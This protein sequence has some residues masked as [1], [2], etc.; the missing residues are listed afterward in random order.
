MTKVLREDL[1]TVYCCRRHE[2][3]IKAFLVSTQ[4]CYI[5]GDMDLHNTHVALFAFL[6]QQWLRERATVVR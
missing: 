5:V 2:F 4:Y 3:A 6:L 1:N